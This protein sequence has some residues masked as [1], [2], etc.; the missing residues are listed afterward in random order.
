MA[1]LE[2]SKTRKVEKVSPAYCQ[3]LLILER[4]GSIGIV[5]LSGIE[6][7]EIEVQGIDHTVESVKNGR[8]WRLLAPGKTYRV[9]AAHADY[10]AMSDFVEVNLLDR[11]PSAALNFELESKEGR[12]LDLVGT[13]GAEVLKQKP[14]RPDGF[15]IPPEYEYHHFKELQRFLAF[16]QKNYENITRLYSVGKSVEGRELWVLEISDNPGVNMHA[17]CIKCCSFPLTICIQSLGP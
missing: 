3:A 5:S 6:G 2:L 17:K 4:T 13:T 10:K 9:R 14:L 15:V 7:A 11:Q 12:N 16:Y 8:Y 1:S